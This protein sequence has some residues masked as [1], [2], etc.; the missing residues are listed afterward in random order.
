MDLFSEFYGPVGENLQVFIGIQTH[1]PRLAQGIGPVAFYFCRASYRL[2]R[3]MRPMVARLRLARRRCQAVSTHV[4]TSFSR[5]P[6]SGKRNKTGI[7]E[8][9][10]GVPDALNAE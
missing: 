5:A 8:A 3:S 7:F 1:Y 10:I 2:P 6:Y 9:G 4:S